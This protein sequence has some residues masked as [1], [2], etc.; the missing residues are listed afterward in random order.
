MQW[1]GYEMPQ[2]KEWNDKKSHLESN[3]KCN[4]EGMK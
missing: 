3:E 2:G 1:G 4:E